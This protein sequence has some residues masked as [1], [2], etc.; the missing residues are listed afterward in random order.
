[1]PKLALRQ[2]NHP[3]CSVLVRRGYCDAHRRP[4]G[5]ER[6]RSLDERKTLTARRFYSGYRWTQA[7]R[8][9]RQDEPLCRRCKAAGITVVGELVHH[10]PPLEILLREGLDPYDSRYFETLCGRCH[11]EELRRPTTVHR[12]SRSIRDLLAGKKIEN[13]AK[14]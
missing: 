8:R 2:C 14:M 11:L 13:P 1:M 12:R 3:G 6:L 9:H 5:R 10:N 7:S 4:E